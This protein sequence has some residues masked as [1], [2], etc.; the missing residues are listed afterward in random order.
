M[1]RSMLTK[2]DAATVGLEMGGCIA[3]GAVLGTY[4]DGQAGTEPWLTLLFLFCGTAAAAKALMRV[5]KKVKAEMELDDES[6][7]EGAV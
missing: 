4:L 3:V 6:P 5:A 2:A 7:S 1:K